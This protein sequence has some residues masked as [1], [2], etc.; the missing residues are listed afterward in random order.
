MNR[1]QKNV[2]RVGVDFMSL[3]HACVLPWRSN[4]MGVMLCS[5]SFRNTNIMDNEDIE[6]IG[7]NVYFWIWN[8][9]NKSPR[10][11]MIQV[12][13]LFFG[14]ER[15]QMPFF[16]R[17]KIMTLKKHAIKCCCPLRYCSSQFS[18]FYE[19][20]EPLHVSILSYQ[21]VVSEPFVAFGSVRVG[22]TIK[23]FGR[24]K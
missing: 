8:R 19:P 3:K 23:P 16:V 15:L 13:N 20:R 14:Y 5:V 6:Q 1:G 24:M 4:N 2:H 21:I 18:V 17:S 22:R 12:P 10:N 7:T 9:N 11:F